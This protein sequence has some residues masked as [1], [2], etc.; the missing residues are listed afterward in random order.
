M[1]W[2]LATVLLLTVGVGTGMASLVTV[3][4][5]TLG[6]TTQDIT[7]P[8]SPGYTLGDVTFSYGYGTSG[9]STASVAS[10]G[11]TGTSVEDGFSDFSYLAIDFS[12]PA[13]FLSFNFT[14]SGAAGGLLT[15]A[16]PLVGITP[17]SNQG[18]FY[19]DGTTGIGAFS[20]DLFGPHGLFDEATVAFNSEDAAS[21]RVFNVQY[22]LAGTGVPEPGTYA[23]LASGLFLLGFGRRKLLKRRS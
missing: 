17:G 18:N 4:F 22:E 10:N 5:S 3:D 8:G 1:K 12:S 13:D 23:L 6:T 15:N 2:I 21:F 19:T 20:T 16:D 7:F 9:G 14:L 11:V